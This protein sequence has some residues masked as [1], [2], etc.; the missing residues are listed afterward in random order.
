MN[1]PIKTTACRSFSLLTRLNYI[2]LFSFIVLIFLW[3]KTRFMRS[4]FS[5]NQCRFYPSCSDYF[6]EAI[7]KHGL[8]FG[9]GLSIKRLFRCHPLCE[10]GVD[11]VPS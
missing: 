7:K 1:C 5:L 9:L 2:L 11:E 8:L 6:L 4:L 10:G 3:Q